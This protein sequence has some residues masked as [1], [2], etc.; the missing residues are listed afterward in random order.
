MGTRTKY[1][2]INQKNVFGKEDAVSVRGIG[3]P[4][5]FRPNQPM[6]MKSGH[7]NASQDNISE[8]R[9]SKAFTHI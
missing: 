4:G 1:R 6:S 5:Y 8:G 9:K 3:G 2:R 7:L